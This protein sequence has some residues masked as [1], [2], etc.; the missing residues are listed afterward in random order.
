MLRKKVHP[1]YVDSWQRFNKTKLPTKEEFYRNLN[2]E[3]ITNGGYKH[4]K[5]NW[6]YF[7]LKNLGDYLLLAEL[8]TTETNVLEYMNLV[9]LTF[10]QCQS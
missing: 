3:N 5:N 7:E 10:Y 1:Y 8:K 6:S 2:L 9:L 4:R